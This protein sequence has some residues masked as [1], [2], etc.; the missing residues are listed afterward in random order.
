[1]TRYKR[2]KQAI[3]V[4]GKI[5]VNKPYILHF[6]FLLLQQIVSNSQWFAFVFRTSNYFLTFF[7]LLFFLISLTNYHSS[8]IQ[9]SN[10]PIIQ[11]FNHSLFSFILIFLS[12]FFFFSLINNRAR[13]KILQTF[14]SSWHVESLHASH[15]FLKF[16]LKIHS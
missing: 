4:S 2:R 1:M 12:Q 3:M 11:S 6:F 13:T 5:K 15:S 7:G 9:S 16:I 8:I 10:H 14:P